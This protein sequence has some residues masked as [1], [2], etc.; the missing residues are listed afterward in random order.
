MENQRQM[1]PLQV[2]KTGSS[3]EK[4]DSPRGSNEISFKTSKILCFKSLKHKGLSNKKMDSDSVYFWATLNPMP[5]I[6]SWKFSYDAKFIDGVLKYIPPPV[7]ATG[8]TG[9]ADSTGSSQPPPTPL[10]K[11]EREVK[12][13]KSVIEVRIRWDHNYFIEALGLKWPPN[14][15]VIEYRN[16]RSTKLTEDGER[17]KQRTEELIEPFHESMAFMTN[18]FSSKLRECGVIPKISSCH[19]DFFLQDSDY[20]QETEL[21]ILVPWKSQI[22][23]I[24]SSDPKKRL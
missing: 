22:G 6:D 2:P 21:T 18:L 1:F 3:I 23:D 15:M 12:T 20:I 8:P 7:G 13:E 9:P 16:V 4:Q 10:T 19:V 24:L 5:Q 14:I 11:E 17:L